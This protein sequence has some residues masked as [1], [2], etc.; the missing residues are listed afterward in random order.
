MLPT[1]EENQA[2]AGATVPGEAPQPRTDFN[3]SIYADATLAGLSMLIPI[4][5]L[6]MLF[7][8]F[9][10]RR[11]AANIARSRGGS[12]APE[13]TAFLN[14]SEEGCIEGCLLMPFKLVYELVKRVSKKLLY[15]LTI[16]DAADRISYYWH[17]AFLVDYALLLGHLNT[18]ELAVRSKCAME[19]AL[20]MTEVSPLWQFARQLASSSR[21][22]FGS[23]RLARRGK[24]D[25]TIEQKRRQL[26][27]H[28]GDFAGYLR[29]LAI[30]YN[31][32]FSGPCSPNPDARNLW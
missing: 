18:M 29:T 27:E 31:Q 23:L 26:A 1:G 25:S 16:K 8:D 4:P 2:A 22:I 24:T 6:D 9:F 17:R 21:N 3:W 10:R 19:R 13:I 32:A 7:E 12:I 30:R 15:F 14:R 11:M 28:W 20:E 5:L